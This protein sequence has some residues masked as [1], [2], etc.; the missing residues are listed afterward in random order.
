MKA[1][2]DDGE[3]RVVVLT[4]AGRRI[5][6]GRRH[7]R[8]R[9]RRA[10]RGRPE[11][12]A[13]VRH[14]PARARSDPLL[15]FPRRAQADHRDDQR[16]DRKGS[17]CST[18]SSVTCASP[19]RTRSSRPPSAA[20]AVSA[21][22]GMAWNPGRVVG[23]AHALELLLS[24][25]KLDGREAV[26]IGLVHQIHP[27]ERLAEATYA[28]A[29]EMAEMVSPRSTRVMKQQVYD[30]PFQTLAEAVIAANQDTPR[31]TGATTFARAPGPSSRSARRGSA[32]TE[33]IRTATSAT[34]T[35][36]CLVSLTG[37]SSSSSSM[38]SKPTTSIAERNTARVRSRSPPTRGR[39]SSPRCCCPPSAA[40]ACGP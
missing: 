6:R 19:P 22:F 40:S 30:V 38:E 20:L 8:V 2:V 9:R 34:S 11:G 27:R 21:E 14:E 4:G 28:Y 23:H 29:A 33:R 39:G 36:D 26:R 3:V 15:W 25:R 10:R 5:L 13:A 35:T 17:A 31:A 12:R 1:A 18:P 32:A 16:G 24:G 37:R 7:H